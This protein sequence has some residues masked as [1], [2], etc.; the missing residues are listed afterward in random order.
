MPTTYDK[1][2]RDLI[3]EIIEENDERPVTHVAADE[4]Y[5][6]RLA[7]KLTEEAMEFEDSRDLEELADVLEVIHAVLDDRDETMAALEA[8][9]REKRAECGGFEERI[10]LDR[11]ESDG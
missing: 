6:D 8:T 1:L 9:R 11:V 10:V 7:E 5:A 3:P 4:E 2:V